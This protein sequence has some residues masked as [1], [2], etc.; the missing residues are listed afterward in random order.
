MD[1]DKQLL[2]EAKSQS[3]VILMADEMHIKEGLVFKHGTGELVGYSD[4]WDINDLL[5]FER[6]Q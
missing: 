5:Q 1:L 2:H 6:K 4:L 3:F